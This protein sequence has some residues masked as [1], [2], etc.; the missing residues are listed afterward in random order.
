MARAFRGA[1]GGVAPV[2]LGGSARGWWRVCARRAGVWCGVVVVEG[3][4]WHR[5]EM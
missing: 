3:G 4:E 1:A 5:K 2:A